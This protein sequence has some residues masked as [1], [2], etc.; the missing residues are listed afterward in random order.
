MRT[1]IIASSF[2]QSASHF[3]FSDS[4][5]SSASLLTWRPLFKQNGGECFWGSSDVAKLM[6][7]FLKQFHPRQLRNGTPVSSDSKQSHWTQLFA[8]WFCVCVCV[9]LKCSVNACLSTCTQSVLNGLTWND[10]LPP[11]SQEQNTVRQWKKMDVTNDMM[12]EQGLYRPGFHV[13][14]FLL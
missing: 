11:D 12:G 6:G 5:W 9:C 13:C 14:L 1:F 7:S 4:G 2:K 8:L 10:H 3:S